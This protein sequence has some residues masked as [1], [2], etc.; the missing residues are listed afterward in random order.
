MRQRALLSMPRDLQDVLAVQFPFTNPHQNSAVPGRF[1][2]KLSKHYN[3]ES[4]P[5]RTQK[6][7]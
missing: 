4:G 1:K 2:F 3:F 6:L 5:L 7:H